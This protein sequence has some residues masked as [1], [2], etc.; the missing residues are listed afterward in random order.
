[1][2]G[3]D[4]LSGGGRL[5]GGALPLQT[6]PPKAGGPLETGFWGGSAERRWWALES[7]R[8]RAWRRIRGNKDEER[9]MHGSMRIGA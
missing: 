7:V 3:G 4:G 2:T 8:D 1:L 9:G 5:H 6:T